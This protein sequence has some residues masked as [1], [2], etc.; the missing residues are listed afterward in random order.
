M[1]A[2][3]AATAKCHVLA[4]LLC[5]A[6]CPGAMH[7]QALLRLRINYLCATRSCKRIV[8]RTARRLRLLTLLTG[9]PWISSSSG[10]FG[11]A[12]SFIPRSYK[13]VR[14]SG[15]TMSTLGPNFSGADCSEAVSA[16]GS[17]RS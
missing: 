9:T 2:Q 1:Q 16:V 10:G 7:L 13:H 15:V 4:K 8:K 11:T 14:L 6:A 3:G 17:I 5:V 12:G